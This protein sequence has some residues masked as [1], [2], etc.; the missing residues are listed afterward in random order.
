MSTPLSTITP[1]PQFNE[2]NS[3]NIFSTSNQNTP[4]TTPPTLQINL[5]E[6]NSQNIFSIPNQ[7]N[8]SQQ[9][10]NSTP[11]QSNSTQNLNYNKIESLDQNKQ[12]FL[13]PNTPPTS[14]TSAPTSKIHEI[15][16]YIPVIVNNRDFNKSC[17]LFKKRKRKKKQ[18]SFCTP[19]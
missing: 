19:K 16:K 9:N 8:P 7:N 1:A 13:D 11:N 12:H 10:S 5:I 18:N 6:L 3:Q 17:K 4:S 14:D 2:L 15:K